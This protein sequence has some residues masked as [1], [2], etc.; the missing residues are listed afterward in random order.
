MKR[1]GLYIG[2]GRDGLSPARVTGVLFCLAAA[3]HTPLTGC[4]TK[5]VGSKICES[6]SKVPRLRLRRG[7]IGK[8]HRFCVWGSAVALSRLEPPNTSAIVGAPD[9]T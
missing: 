9:R 2:I 4:W 5:G 3:A 8:R 6:G 7:P 1:L